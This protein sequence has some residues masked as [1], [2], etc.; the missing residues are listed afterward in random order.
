MECRAASLLVITEVRPSI[1]VLAYSR[2]DQNNDVA[3]S[4]MS[5]LINSLQTKR[6]KP[7]L[8]KMARV[9]H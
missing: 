6:L 8:T 7:Q 5:C 9:Q 1:I 2:I 4:H 3:D